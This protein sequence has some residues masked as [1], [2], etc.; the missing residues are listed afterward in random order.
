M[1][2]KHILI[3]LGITAL[4]VG[5]FFGIRYYRKK[6]A[7]SDTKSTEKQLEDLIST[8]TASGKDTFQGL[9][10]DVYKK[11]L[12][13]FLAKVTKQEADEAI[14]I[15]EKKE[16][17][18]TI[19]EKA[20]LLS[21]ITRILSGVMS[22][23]ANTKQVSVNQEQMATPEERRSILAEGINLAKRVN[24]G[25]WISKYQGKLAE[26]QVVWNKAKPTMKEYNALY[27]FLTTYNKSES[28]TLKS[29]SDE[30]KALLSSVMQRL[31]TKAI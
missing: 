3:G 1:K 11:A 18:M 8:F 16:S 23:K 29:F 6:K 28:E 25:N 26:W 21:V 5:G 27:K 17:D 12:D 19:S 24:K 30:E 7:E 13:N 10:P 4:A 20:K 22:G 31:N 9:A 15:A 2:T 14:K